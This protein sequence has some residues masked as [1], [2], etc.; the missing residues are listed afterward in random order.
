MNG[1]VKKLLPLRGTK[2]SSGGVEGGGVQH[3]F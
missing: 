2:Q 3:Q 1:K